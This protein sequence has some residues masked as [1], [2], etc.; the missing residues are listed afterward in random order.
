[1]LEVINKCDMDLRKDL[2]GNIVIVGGNSLV[3]GFV[4]RFEKSLYEIAPQVT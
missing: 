2:L 4:E 1:M 3:P